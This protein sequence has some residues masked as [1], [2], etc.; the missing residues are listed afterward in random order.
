MP[1]LRFSFLLVLLTFGLSGCGASA[2]PPTAAPDLKFT[3]VDGRN[4]DLSALKGK[5]VLVDF[6]A[7]WCPA[8][9]V[10][11]PDLVQLYQKYHAQGLEIIGVS[12]DSDKQAMLNAVKE[13][14]IAW[15]QYF[16]GQGMDNALATRFKI[17]QYP[18]LWLIDKNG[19]LVTP[20]FTS[21]W[22]VD[23]GLPV[24]TPD[25]TRQKVDAAIEKLL[26]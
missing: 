8:C 11:S 25:S 13:E 6:W 20:D 24:Q 22:I 16:D 3:A 2:L 17:A 5:V 19:M 9:R 15:P 1:L 12:V 23:G 18:T 10:I 4:V 7:T 26:K 14:G 21:L